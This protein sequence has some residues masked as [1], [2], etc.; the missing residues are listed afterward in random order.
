[1]AL[2]ML[3]HQQALDEVLQRAMPLEAISVPVG[4]A[5][6]RVLAESVHADTD[7]PPFHKALMDGFAIRSEDLPGGRGVLRVGGRITAGDEAIAEMRPGEAVQI[8]TGAMVPPGANAVVMV[9]QTHRLP[10][11]TIEIA[12]ETLKA[13]QHILWRASVMRAGQPV[14]KPGRTLR[15]A[16][17]GVL[18][19]TGRTDVAVHRPVRAAVL[20][21]GSELVEP[22]GA[23]ESG[24]IR[25]TNGPVLQTLVTSAGGMPE[26]L[27]IAPDERDALAERIRA[28]LSADVLLVSGGC[29][30]GDRDLVPPVLTEVGVEPVFH[31]VAVKPGKPVWFGV[32]DETLVFGLPGHP[33]STIM[34]FELLV[35][36]AFKRMMGLRDAGPDFLRAVLTK[37]YRI[38]SDRPT[39][40]PVEVDY[41]HGRHEATPLESHGSADLYAVTHADG[42]LLFPAGEHFHKEGTE[43]DLLLLGY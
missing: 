6:G 20:C 8:M 17:C 2:S 43:L 10:D 27:G 39:F 4:Q 16:E 41:R 24:Q 30:M 26:Y 42:M 1:M 34:S 12:D 13:G 3:T 29:S 15:A 36:P 35:R 18:S 5:L 32:K 14:L 25:N 23:P 11:G 33:V 38:K 19:M 40:L 31:K 7:E 37:D 22:D 21:T 9:E 28:G